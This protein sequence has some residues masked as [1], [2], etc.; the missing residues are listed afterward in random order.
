MS[1]DGIQL[2]VTVSGTQGTATS[3]FSTLH[4]SP[5]PAVVFE[6]GEFL[7]SEWAVSSVAAAPEGAPTFSTSRMAAGGNPGA[8]LSETYNIPATVGQRLV[9]HSRTSANYYP[10]SGG[11]IYL[12][13]F[14][15]QCKTSTP[16]TWVTFTP[17]FEQGERRF[18]AENPTGFGGGHYCEGAVWH[19]VQWG[20]LSEFFLVS[21]PA[22]AQGESCPDYSASA[23]PL[24]F[25]FMIVAR[26]IS[27]GAS[28]AITYDYDNWK[29]TVWRR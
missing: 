5:M 6:D 23:A 2:R 28:Q 8:F 4:V 21:G 12:V 13:E 18:A 16:L 15:L 27:P 11:S 24:R 10:T 29:V 22:C 20:P 19:G 7:D 14:S 3:A 1:D 9:F 26:S 17:M 25:G